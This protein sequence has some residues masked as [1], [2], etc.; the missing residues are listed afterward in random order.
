MIRSTHA[1]AAIA[2]LIVAGDTP[3]RIQAAPG[4]SLEGQ[5]RRSRAG[6]DSQDE[7][8][9]HRADGGAAG[10]AR[11]PEAFPDCRPPGRATG[12]RS[13]RTART[14]VGYAGYLDARH[15]EVLASVGG[16][17]KV[18]DYRYSVQRLRGRADRRAGRSAAGA[19]R[20]ARCQQGRAAVRRHVVDAAF[21]GW[22]TGG[23]W[24]QLGGSGQAGED[25]IIGIVDSGIWPESL[26]FTDRDDAAVTRQQNGKR[27]LSTACPAG[28]ASVRP[29]SSSPPADCNQK[30]IG[31]QHF[32][33][34]WG[35]DAGASRRDRPWEFTS[36]R[37]YNGHGTHTAST[38]GGNHGVAADR[39]GGGVRS[40]QRHGAAR[41]HRG[42]QGA[43]VDAGRVDGQRLHV[44]PRRRDRPGGR[45]RR[46][47]HQLL[48]Q[49]HRRPTSSIRS[50]RVP[51]RGR[52]R[53]VRGGFGRQQRAGDGHGG[54]SR[55]RGSPR[56][57]Q[58]R[59]TATA[60]ARSRWATARPSPARRLRPPSAPAPLDR[61]DGCRPARRRS[62]GAGALLHGGRQRR[63]R[64]CS[65]RPR[66]P[67]RSS[68][69]IAAS[70]PASTRAWRCRRPAASG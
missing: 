45:R 43:V 11:M 21:L 2:V 4:Q 60:R 1:I 38:A 41:A 17:R 12:K 10:R 32:N 9:L 28:T 62:D 59:T 23:L 69:A 63:R 40:D 26:S 49:R 36:P 54:A 64:R 13:I 31:A 56:L 29:A 27:R 34:G 48:G 55:A 53:R 3:A 44:R 20:R 19:S 67:A 65:I 58:A 25:I 35:G 57:P 18:Y 51:V 46:G 66:W 61:L 7:H 6:G 37:D 33:A 52:R 70:T 47:R 24:D 42:L 8:H 22:T 50:S 15:D 30:L 68:S 14:V 5:V 16:G 39:A